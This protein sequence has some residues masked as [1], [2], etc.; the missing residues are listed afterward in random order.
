MGSDSLFRCVNGAG[1]GRDRGAASAEYSVLLGVVAIGVIG[2]ALLYGRWVAPLIGGRAPESTLV[3]SLDAVGAW[4]SG[5]GTQTIAIAV[6]LLVVGVVIE[7]ASVIASRT[8]AYGAPLPR[9]VVI[10]YVFG[11]T[12]L[13]A[14]VTLLLRPLLYGS[15][16]AGMPFEPARVYGIVVL[17]VGAALG[18]TCAAMARTSSAK[19]ALVV[20]AGA[21]L[22]LAGLGEIASIIRSGPLDVRFIAVTAGLLGASIA[23]AFVASAFVD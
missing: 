2:F 22:A 4:A 12:F 23:G 3:A 13:A 5:D 20:G 17:G 21:G 19:Q 9:R 14:G 7:T 1:S 18:M 16:L 15:F 10:G 6:G 11:N 8:R